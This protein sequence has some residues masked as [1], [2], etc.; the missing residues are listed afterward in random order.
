MY[1]KTKKIRQCQILLVKTESMAKWFPNYSN[2][3]WF[4][5][6]KTGNK[7]QTFTR[8]HLTSVRKYNNSSRNKSQY[9]RVACRKESA[10]SLPCLQPTLQCIKWDFHSSSSFH[11]EII[12][13]KLAAL[14]LQ[15]C[16]KGV[17]YTKYMVQ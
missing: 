17:Y 6:K 10:M 1:L 12:N 15:M 16:C 13:G 3:P 5:Y 8:K 4:N 9:R 2:I 11:N 14:K 7:N